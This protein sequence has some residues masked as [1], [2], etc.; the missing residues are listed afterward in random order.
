MSD[1]N[2]TVKRDSVS[3]LNDFRRG[4]HV[5]LADLQKEYARRKEEDGGTVDAIMGRTVNA[6]MTAND[7]VYSKF[8]KDPKKV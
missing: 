8:S 1:V 6:V 3:W 5:N 7:D 2:E 4:K